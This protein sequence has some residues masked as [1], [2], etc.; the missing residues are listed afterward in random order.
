MLGTS[1]VVHQEIIVEHSCMFPNLIKK[2]AVEDVRKGQLQV[3]GDSLC[4]M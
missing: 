2:T 1:Y 4:T 3:V